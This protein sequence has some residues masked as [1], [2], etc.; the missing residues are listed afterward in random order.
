VHKKQPYAEPQVLNETG[1]NFK[2]KS[3]YNGFNN[4]N[5][6]QNYS[7]IGKND[8][9]FNTVQNNDN[10]YELDDNFNTTKNNIDSKNS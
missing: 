3:K 4:L 6:T 8:K 9:K 5:K 2:N 1:I 7:Q 10:Q